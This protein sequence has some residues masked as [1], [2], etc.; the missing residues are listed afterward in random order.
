MQADEGQGRRGG[1]APRRADRGLGGPGVPAGGLLASSVV[2]WKLVGSFRQPFWKVVGKIQRSGW[3][4]IGGFQVRATLD[5][6]GDCAEAFLAARL[7]DG[8][9]FDEAESEIEWVG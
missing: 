1:G 6:H 4:P 7:W 3:K 2:A 9:A 5:A 8:M